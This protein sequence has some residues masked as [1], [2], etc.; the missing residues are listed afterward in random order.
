MSSVNEFQGKESLN[1]DDFF[2]ASVDLLLAGEQV[3]SLENLNKHI[4]APSRADTDD[5]CAVIKNPILSV[6]I[7]M[8]A[9]FEKLHFDHMENSHATNQH[10]QTIAESLSNIAESLG[11]IA[12]ST[13]NKG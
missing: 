9:R 8:L 5:A 7:A 4:D 13:N 1:Q 2:C 10:L 12:V 6:G 3:H 11:V